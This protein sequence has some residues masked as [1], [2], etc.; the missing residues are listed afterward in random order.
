MRRLYI[1]SLLAMMIALGIGGCGGG[2]VEGT[3]ADP[4]GTD[5]ITFADAAGCG[6]V[7]PNGALTLKATVKNAAGT[8]VVGREVSFG[9]VTNASGASLTSYNANT[10]A[11]GEA[12][13]LYMAGATTGSDVVRASIS[14]GAKMDVNIT[15]GGGSAGA[16]T[17]SA[18]PKT[19]AAVGGQ[20]VVT[21]TVKNAD[22]AVSG[23]TVNFSVVAGGSAGGSVSP[24][25]AITD[26]SGNAVTTYR[27]GAVAKS[28]D[29][30]QASI[31]IGGNTYGSAVTIDTP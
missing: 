7:S 3:S 14:N 5:S 19:L 22:V 29:T 18:S 6:A 30:V 28:T 10:N 23:V 4:L 31:T 11:A 9:F 2:V 13:I 25:A 26:G 15:V 21:A 24:A 16:L 1:L 27:G 17:I 20:S 12:T 8:A